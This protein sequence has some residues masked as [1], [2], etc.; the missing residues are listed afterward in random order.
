MLIVDFDGENQQ[1]K[2]CQVTLEEDDQQELEQIT[3]KGSH[4]SQKRDQCPGAAEL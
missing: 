2:R 1:V 4:Q 3:R